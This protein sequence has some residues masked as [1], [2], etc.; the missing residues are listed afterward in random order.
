MAVSKKS[1]FE[2]GAEGMVQRKMVFLRFGGRICR[3]IEKNVAVRCQISPRAPGKT[4]YMHSDSARGLSG[5]KDIGGA[6][7]GGE[8][9]EHIARPSIA[10]YLLGEDQL[11]GKIVGAGCGESRVASQR[12]SGERLLQTFG[13]PVRLRWAREKK[14]FH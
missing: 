4:D 5:G 14:S 11:G 10:I 7:R 1:F 9:P 13:Q 8:S 2:H 6:A 12:Q 3:Y